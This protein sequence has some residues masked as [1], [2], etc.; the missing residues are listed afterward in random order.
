VILV[1]VV[2]PP[3][4]Q[5]A[6]EGLPVEDPKITRRRIEERFEPVLEL[7]RSLR[8]WI[9][10]EIVEGWA[11]EQI[12]NRADADEVDFIV[13]GRHNRHRLRGWLVGSTSEAVM[14]MSACSVMIV[15]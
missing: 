4:I 12:R 2:E 15:R 1:G 9:R 3:N 8:V 7:G 14:R 11:A 6:G 10:V 5:A 13:I